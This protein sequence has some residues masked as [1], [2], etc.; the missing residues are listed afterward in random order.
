MAMYRKAG[1]EPTGVD[2]EVAF[3]VLLQTSGLGPVRPNIALFNWFD[4]EST[5]ED[6]P[7]MR[8]Y[9][10]YLRTALRHG[11]NVVVLATHREALE[12]L[13]QEGKGRRRIDIW[14]HGDASSKLAL[15]LAY[16]MSRR[17][18]WSAARLRV[19]TLGENGVS[20]ADTLRALGSELD[21]VRIPAEVKVV[22]SATWETL[23]VESEGTSLAFVTFRVSAEG[24][25][26]SAGDALPGSLEGL[27]PMAL[28]LAARDIDLDAQPDEGP[29][30]DFARAEAASEEAEARAREQRARAEK[31]RAVAEEAAEKLEAARRAETPDPE[32]AAAQKEADSVGAAASAAERKA[33]KAEAKA[34]ELA[35]QVPTTEGGAGEAATEEPPEEGAGDRAL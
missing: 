29:Q 23:R 30:A 22:E 34:Q 18:P 12:K 8:S 2:V 10:T 4:R 32:V 24:L 20:E 13:A 21:E 9:G 33:A 25:R 5:A 16:L 7:A 26:D 14:W 11:C 35:R 6:A 1:L 27:P 17:A 28:V 19:L 3:P 15:L 31:L